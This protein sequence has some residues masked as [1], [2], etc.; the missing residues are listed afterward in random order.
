MGSRI[1]YDMPQSI[2]HLHAKF[3]VC[4][5]SSFLQ[6]LVQRQVRLMLNFAMIYTIGIHTLYNYIGLYMIRAI[7]HNNYATLWLI[8]PIAMGTVE[9]GFAL[10]EFC[11]E[12]YS[13]MLSCCSSSRIIS[14]NIRS[15][16][17]KTHVQGVLDSHSTKLG[18]QVAACHGQ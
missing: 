7:T 16:H 18:P 3:G 17:S 13:A 6:H 15:T 14:G 4:T 8:P 9:P 1:N 5:Y 12:M 2:L 11:S 10:L